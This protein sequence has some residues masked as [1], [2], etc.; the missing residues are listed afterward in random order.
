MDIRFIRQ[1]PCGSKHG[2]GTV[3]EAEVARQADYKLAAKIR[4]KPICS[5][6]LAIPDR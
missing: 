5:L 1:Q 4:P 3:C 2:L 6:R